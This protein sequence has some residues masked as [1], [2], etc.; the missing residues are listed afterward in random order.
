MTK[1]NRF[2]SPPQ[3]RAQVT[4][5]S[6]IFTSFWITWF[7]G[8]ID[9]I[10]TLDKNSSRTE[11][12]NVLD[13]TDPLTDPAD[14]ELSIDLGVNTIKISKTPIG[15][16]T[17]LDLVGLSRLLIFASKAVAVTVD[18]LT[19]VDS[20]TFWTITNTSS[21]GSGALVVTDIVSVSFK[22]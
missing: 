13:V 11:L 2:T 10:A 16:G 15:G 21:D 1:V 20:G 6:N 14:G 19:V 9:A 18:G 8:I 17:T 5:K 4:D 12:F 3:A 22:W 7:I